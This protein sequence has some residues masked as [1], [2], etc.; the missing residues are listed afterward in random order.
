MGKLPNHGVVL[1]SVNYRLGVFGFLAHPEL[2]GE[3]AHHASGNYGLMDQILALKWVIANIEQFGGDAKNITVFGQ[4]AGAI[5]TGMLM[6]SPAK[7][8]FQKAIQESGSAFTGCGDPWQRLRGMGRSLLYGDGCAGGSG[9]DCVF[10]RIPA[11]ELIKKWTTHEPRPRF[12]PVVDGWVLP[13]SPAEVFAAGEESAIP[14]LFG[15]TT[16]EFESNAS[17]DECCG[18]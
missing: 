10:A 16:K 2:T 7:G 5:D 12:G 14:L 3:S 17:A 6:V 1:V 11:G 18:G 15:T 9:A 8:L 13:K 4:S